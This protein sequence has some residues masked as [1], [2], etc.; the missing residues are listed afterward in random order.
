MIWRFAKPCSGVHHTERKHSSQGSQRITGLKHCRLFL[1]VVILSL[2][3]ADAGA[4]KP[5]QVWI[6]TWGAAQQIPEPQ[7]ALAAK[8][9]RDATV[10]QIFHLSAGGSRLRVHLSN[11]FGSEALHSRA[12]PSGF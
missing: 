8:D 2:G 5:K 7:N 11:A 9:L 1:L 10:R 4:G 6:A 3:H 12:T